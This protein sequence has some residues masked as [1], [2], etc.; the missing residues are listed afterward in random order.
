MSTLTS[1]MITC[2]TSESMILPNAAPMITP[3]ARSTTLPLKANALNSSNSESACFAGPA[4][5]ALSLFD[6]FKAFAFKGNV[7]DLAVGV[8]IGAAFG[9]IID[10]LVKHVIMPL[11]SVLIPGKQSYVDWKFTI[12]DK[13]IP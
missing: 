6:E 3:T 12:N 7:V 4:K 9:K 1:G 10:S 11:V 5:Q 2:L 8:I 13:D